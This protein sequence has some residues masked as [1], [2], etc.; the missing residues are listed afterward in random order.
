MVVL[1]PDFCDGKAGNRQV[2]VRSLRAASIICR[3]YIERNDLRSHTW[4]GGQVYEGAQLV[5]EVCHNGSVWSLDG[6]ELDV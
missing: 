2:S 5:A 6:R 1:L 4:S 3:D